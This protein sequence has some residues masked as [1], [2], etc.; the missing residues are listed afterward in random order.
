MENRIINQE[1]DRAIFTFACVEDAN[2]TIKL[3]K[4][5]SLM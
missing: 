5:I 4:I 2:Q 1:K 3:K